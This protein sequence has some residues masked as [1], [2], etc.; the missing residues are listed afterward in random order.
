MRRRRLILAVVVGV[1]VSAGLGTF[2]AEPVASVIEDCLKSLGFRGRR[3]GLSPDYYYYY[4]V[5][6]LIFVVFT[7][8][9]IIVALLIARRRGPGDDETRCRK[10]G[11]ILRG[12]SEPRCP[13]CGERI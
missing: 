9:G 1:L 12:I 2:F 7:P 6:F 4:L 13:E 3:I 10:C 8:P 5:A 11:Y